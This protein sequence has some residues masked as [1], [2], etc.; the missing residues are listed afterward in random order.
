MKKTI[1]F[2]LIFMAFISIGA[3][4]AE[5]NTTASPIEDVEIL[6]DDAY[7]EILTDK[8]RYDL[9]V[10]NIP[11]ECEISEFDLY[12]DNE[13]VDWHG[14]DTEKDTSFR[15]FEGYYTYNFTKSQHALKLDFKGNTHYAHIQK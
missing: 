8:D 7:G 10:Y 3:A 5:D 9:Y 14:K 2:A 12:I 4:S 1:L 6:Y 15:H 11:D 13:T